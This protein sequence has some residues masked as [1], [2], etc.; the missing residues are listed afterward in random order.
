MRQFLLTKKVA[1][2]TKTDVISVEDGAIGVFYNKDGVLSLTTKGTEVMKEALLVLGRSVEKGGPITLP[3]HKN[4]FSYVKGVYAGAT[5]FA[6][7]FTV[8]A[9]TKVGDYSIIIVKK[10]VGFNER[11]KWTASVHVTND[12]MSAGDL[13]TAL[14]KAISDNADASGVSATASTGTITITASVSGVD[15]EIKGADLLM[16]TD[17]EV[18]TAGK[19]AYGD[20]AYIKD[21]ADKAAADAGFEYTYR[22][23]GVDLYPNYPINPLAQAN[24]ADEGYTIFTLRFA[25]PRD[26]R[27]VDNVVNQIVQVAFPTGAGAIAS[28]ETIC[29]ALSAEVVVSAE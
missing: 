27:T 23:A 19:T 12:S 25:E 3:I 15:Y 22:D 21:L 1:Y 28:F 8:A 20:A 14:A 13:A 5:T 17:G 2:T 10:G 29:K 9:P 26:V 18:T 24:A 4:N 7:K 16:G 6:A 11:N